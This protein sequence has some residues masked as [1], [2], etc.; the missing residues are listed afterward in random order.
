MKS[1]K[2]ATLLLLVSF[3]AFK[4]KAQSETFKAFKVDVALGYAAP[5]GS[6]SKAGILFAVEPK[7]SMSDQLTLGLRM[8]WALTAYSIEKDG[9]SYAG[10]IKS[11][12]SYLATADYM[13]NTNKVRPFAGL[14]VG[15]YSVAG[16]SFSSDNS[17]LQTNTVAS[18]T[19]FGFAPRVGAELGHFRAAIEYNFAGKDDNIKYN[20]LGFKIGAFFG[21]GRR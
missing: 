17:S 14:G 4:A 13:F 9:V 8:E 3:S 20:Y 11:T 6:G 1:L 5:S 10:D 19:K 16:A 15:I 12:G 21:G 2:I 18:S 7:Y